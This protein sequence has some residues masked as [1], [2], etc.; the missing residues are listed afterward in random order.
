VAEGQTA[1]GSG[2]SRPDFVCSAQLLANGLM[3]CEVLSVNFAIDEQSPVKVAPRSCLA[4]G[5][6]TKKHQTDTFC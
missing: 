1:E 2:R 5:E 6:R 3:D 4:V